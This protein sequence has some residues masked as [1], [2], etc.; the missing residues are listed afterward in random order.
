MAS[1]GN[2]PFR[3]LMQQLGAGATVS[4][5]ISSHGINYK[6]DHTLKMLRIDPQEEN[7]GIQLFGEDAASI[8][9]AALGGP[10]G[11]SQMDRY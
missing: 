10:R 3:L 2:A 4:E 8:S 5:L 6:N 7:I 1:I 11:R 9:A